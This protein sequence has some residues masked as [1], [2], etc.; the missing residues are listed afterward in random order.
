MGRA[1][2]GLDTHTM[3]TAGT[4]LA[5]TSV[6]RKAAMIIWNPSVGVMPTNRP[7][8]T[9]RATASGVPRACSTDRAHRRSRI[10][11]ALRRRMAMSDVIPATRDR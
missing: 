9:P 3:S 7:I 5:P 11:T 4:R 8:P 6:V 10:L 2:S 1:V